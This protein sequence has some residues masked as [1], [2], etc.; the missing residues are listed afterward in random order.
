MV[1]FS[2]SSVLHADRLAAFSDFLLA[3]RSMRYAAQASFRDLPV[4]VPES[5]ASRLTRGS[6]RRYVP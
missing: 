6:A 3:L 2:D 1:G 5:S 4:G